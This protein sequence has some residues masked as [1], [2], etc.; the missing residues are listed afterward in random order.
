[1]PSRRPVYGPYLVAALANALD[2]AKNKQRARN[3]HHRYFASPTRPKQ[4][5]QKLL[6]AESAQPQGKAAE[7]G[8]R[9]K[10]N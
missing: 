6:N 3:E 5:L 9:G 1:M 4:H 10:M 8:V 2:A 7:T